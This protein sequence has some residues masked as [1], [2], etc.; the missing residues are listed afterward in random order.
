[1][2]EKKLFFFLFLLAIVCTS[3]A[4]NADAPKLYVDCT[5]G[6][7]YT[8]LRAE[9]DFVHHVR[10]RQSSDVFIQLTRL[11]TGGGGNEYSLYITGMD[12]FAG[13]VDTIIYNTDANAT[14]NIRRDAF[15]KNVR[16]A[17]L[18]F[19]MQTSLA[20]NL[21]YTITKNEQ[22]EST[23]EIVDPWKQWVFRVGTN[24]SFNGEELFQSYRFSGYLS[25]GKV[26]EGF[27]FNLFA[28]GDYNEQRFTL[29]DGEKLVS[30]IR[31]QEISS[32]YVKSISDHWSVGATSTAFTSTFSNYDFSISLRPAIEYSVYPYA[33][34]TKRQFTALYSVG[35]YHYQY[36][37]TTIFGVIKETLFRQRLELGYEQIED[38]GELDLEVDFSMYLHDPQLIRLSFSPSIE[39]NIFKGFG[40]RIG[41]YV[42][43]IRDQLNIP[44]VAASSEEVLLRIIQLKSNYNFGGFMSINYR[45]GSSYNNV[46][47]TRF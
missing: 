17:L 46:V 12:R 34:A 33:E 35:P 18:P 26:T 31:S 4:Q 45:F 44:N 36:V 8:Y 16:K 23:Q 38:W 14:D 40:L 39:W 37:D 5:T 15:I 6:C 41:G 13:M 19:I 29:E 30:T 21:D 3:K 7:D 1:M 10:D 43:M 27:K 9:V 22:G 32:T 11:R 28:S 2:L 24:G 42:S 25:V 47:N 20:G